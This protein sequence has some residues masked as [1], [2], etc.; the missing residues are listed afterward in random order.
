M[1]V[2]GSFED[3]DVPRLRAL[4]EECFARK[5]DP[6]YFVRKV[7]Y[8]VY[9]SE[10]YRATA[11]LTLEDGVP[12]LDKFAVTPEAQGE[13]IGASIWQ[14]LRF[15][16]PKVFWRARA[17]NPINGWYAQNAD[18]LYKSDPFWV[19]WCGMESW[20]EIEA[21]VTCALAMPATL[22]DAHPHE[23]PTS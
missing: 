3:V 11:I 9:L 4:L 16:N 19:F 21:C 18:G 1:Q 13:G 23:E 12:Y 22:K 7:P 8:R 5:L 6:S 17:K 2:Y 15:E 10:S 20:A 14:R